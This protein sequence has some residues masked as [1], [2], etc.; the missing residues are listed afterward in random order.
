MAVFVRRLFGIGKLPDELHAQVESEG[1]TY[2]ADYVA[3]TRRFSGTI[4][5][6]RLPHSVASYTGSLA[7]TSERVLATLSMLPRLAG[8]TV[9][10]R[11]DAPQ[12]GPAKVEISSTGLQVDVD[13]SRVD[14]KFSGELSLHYK[15]AIP[16]DVLDG[17]PRRSLA[18]DM[19][20]EYVFRAVGV[21]YSP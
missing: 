13:V 14:E 16:P 21:T 7:F 11:W 17:L 9:N 19:P 18:F 1:L 15:V 20:P 5:G 3:V 10:V 6:V 12:T 4:P 2:L 8:P